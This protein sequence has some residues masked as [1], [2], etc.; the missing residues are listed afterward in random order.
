MP[1]AA[2]A[3][4]TPATGGMSGKCSGASGETVV[5]M[6]LQIPAPCPAQCRHVC[7][8]TEHRAP[9]ACRNSE[10]AAPPSFSGI[11]G[12]PPEEPPADRSDEKRSVLIWARQA[13]VRRVLDRPAYR[14]ARPSR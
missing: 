8:D 1:A 13:S 14:A 11:A 4:L 5:V 2:V 6:G 7:E 12:E 10:L 3:S 9:H